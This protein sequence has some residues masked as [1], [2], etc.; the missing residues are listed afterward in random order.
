MWSDLSSRVAPGEV[1][2]LEG[3]GFPAGHVVGCHDETEGLGGGE[4]ETMVVQMENQLP[5]RHVGHL[6]THT[7]SELL[8]GGGGRKGR[9]GRRGR[10][11]DK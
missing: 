4:D 2:T 9:R 11:E 6:H 7:H 10:S 3:E 5:P 8:V 1:D